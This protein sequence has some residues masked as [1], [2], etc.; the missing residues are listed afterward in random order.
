LATIKPLAYF[1][2][3]A[4]DRRVNDA[5]ARQQVEEKAAESAGKK[6]RVKPIA[7]QRL[8]IVGQDFIFDFHLP[9]NPHRIGGKKKQGY[10]FNAVS[11]YPEGG[12]LIVGPK[13]TLASIP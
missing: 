5:A 10:S 6:I 9:N 7:P 11:A 2:A 8:F 4:Y 3:I 13:G 1:S 12:A